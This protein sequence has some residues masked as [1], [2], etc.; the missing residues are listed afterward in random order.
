TYARCERCCTYFLIDVP[1]DLGRYYPSDY[2]VLPTLEGLREQARDEAYRIDMV[3]AHATGGRL[4][5]IGPGHGI[6]AVQA[7]DAGFETV[8]VELDPIAAEYLRDTV[9]VEVVESGSPER[10]LREL[11]PSRVIAMWH[12]LEHLPRPWE[13]LSAAADNLESGGVLVVATPNPRAFGFR[14]LRGRWTHVDAP[15]HLFL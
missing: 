15:R 2:F 10:V 9:G 12:V 8:G 6:F 14:L 5:E 1:E 7:R 4:V 11:P 13:M 3:R